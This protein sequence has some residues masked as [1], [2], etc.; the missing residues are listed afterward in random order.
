MVKM[1]ASGSPRLWSS[2]PAVTGTKAAV[3]LYA[4]ARS[5]RVML[6]SL[7]CGS[8]ASSLSTFSR[9]RLL[10]SSVAEA[11]VGWDMSIFSGWSSGG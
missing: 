8:R 4:I 9:M 7:E 11:G 10:S 3:V 5:P 6:P 2:P 1:A